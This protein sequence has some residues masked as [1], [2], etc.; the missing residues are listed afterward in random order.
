MTFLRFDSTAE[1]HRDFSH[2]NVENENY[3]IK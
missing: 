3:I 2:L 1:D